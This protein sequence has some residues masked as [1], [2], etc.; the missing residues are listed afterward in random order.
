MAS[1]SRRRRVEATPGDVLANVQPERQH[2]QV[3]LMLQAM[4][5]DRFQLRVHVEERQ[6]DV[7]ELHLAPGGLKQ[8]T[9]SDE[10]VARPG[11]NPGLNAAVGDN[12]G[13]MIGN[14]ASMQRIGAGLSVFLGR[15]VM[16]KT[17]VSGYYNFD[18]HWT[19]LETPDGPPSSGLGPAGIALLISELREQLGLRLVSAKSAQP[20][21][22]VDRAEKPSNGG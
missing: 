6:V 9:P 16:D 19:A 20:F 15:L 22:V 4:L 21:W 11:L 12:S 10:G 5:A 2:A 7:Y 8:M 3:Q 17:G 18:I 14:G 13:R 1:H